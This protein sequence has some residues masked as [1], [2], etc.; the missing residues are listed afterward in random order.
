MAGRRGAP[1]PPEV[2]FWPSMQLPGLVQAHGGYC[3]S[4]RL[5]PFKRATAWSRKA[6]ALQSQPTPGLPDS[7]LHLAVWMSN[8]SAGPA[9][10]PPHPAALQVPRPRFPSPSLPPTQSGGCH[11]GRR[12]R[13]GTICLC[14]IICQ[15]QLVKP[16][17]SAPHHA[18]K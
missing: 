1:P 3:L 11:T 14:V 18:R 4:G 17:P 8:G 15:V 16:Q 6:C 12:V 13:Q 9:P 2:A 10:P 5:S 7:T